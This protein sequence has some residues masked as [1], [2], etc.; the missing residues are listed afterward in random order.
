MFLKENN[1]DCSWDYSCKTQGL[2]LGSS[3]DAE[4]GQAQAQKKKII[5]DGESISESILKKKPTPP[6][7]HDSFSW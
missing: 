1:H 3:A 2:F 5:Y 4:H 7:L 6:L